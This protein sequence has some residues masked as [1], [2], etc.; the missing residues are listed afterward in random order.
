MRELGWDRDYLRD[1]EHRYYYYIKGNKPFRKV[2]MT[3]E[4][5]SQV[6]VYMDNTEKA[7]R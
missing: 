4:N 3:L 1:G 5:S 7:L 2:N 6:R